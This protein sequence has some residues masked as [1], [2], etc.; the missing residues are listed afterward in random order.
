MPRERPKEIA[1]RQKKKEIKYQIR[2]WLRFRQA[3]YIFYMET[4]KG[5]LLIFQEVFQ[6]KELVNT[7]E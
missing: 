5:N 1:K 3:H 2:Q 4:E 7:K 6:Q